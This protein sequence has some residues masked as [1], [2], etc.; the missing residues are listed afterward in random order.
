MQQNT[1]SSWVVVLLSLGAVLA[2]FALPPGCGG[3]QPPPVTPELAG[4]AAR[5]AC[6]QLK[7]NEDRSL[8]LRAADDLQ[9]VLERA[10]AKASNTAQ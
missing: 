9:Q 10:R 1:V 5:L 4:S 8:C 3:Q 7:N 6:S 2:V